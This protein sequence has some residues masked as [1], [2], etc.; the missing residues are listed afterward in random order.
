M[1]YIEFMSRTKKPAGAA[2]YK[3]RIIRLRS[4]PARDL[5]IITAPDEET[6]I[7]K[8]AEQYQ[9]PEALR[10]RLMARRVG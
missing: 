8:A 9:V 10:D 5:G 6:A 4:T 2:E 3:W 1:A 7:K